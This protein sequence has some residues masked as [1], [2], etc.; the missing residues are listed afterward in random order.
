[1]ICHQNGEGSGPMQ[2]PA[3]LPGFRSQYLHNIYNIYSVLSNDNLLT[4][5]VLVVQMCTIHIILFFNCAV[6][7]FNRMVVLS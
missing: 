3:Q 1:M 4:R 6:C 5:S 7:T 2:G